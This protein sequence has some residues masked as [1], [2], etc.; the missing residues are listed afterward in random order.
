M[1][2]KRARRKIASGEDLQE[3]MADFPSVA[4]IFIADAT[5]RLGRQRRRFPR[6]AEWSGNLGSAEF[7]T[8][9]GKRAGPHFRRPAPGQIR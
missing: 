7:Q 5:G 3:E 4:R 2:R 1:H 9:G 8:G 6:R